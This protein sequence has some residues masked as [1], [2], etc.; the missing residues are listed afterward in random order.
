MTEFESFVSSFKRDP[1]SFRSSMQ[2]QGDY[3]FAK[4]ARTLQSAQNNLSGFIM[5]DMFGQQLGNHLFEKFVTQYN[6]NLLL[7]M[8]SLGTEEHFFLMHQFNTKTGQWRG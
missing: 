8:N 6:R 3:D 4:V 7:F 5:S 2:S 1:E